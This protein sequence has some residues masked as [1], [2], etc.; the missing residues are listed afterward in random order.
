[1]QNNAVIKKVSLF[2]SAIAALAILAFTIPNLDVA[3]RAVKAIKSGTFSVQ[4]LRYDIAS[5]NIG[6]RSEVIPV[7][8][9][10]SPKD[11]MRQVFVPA[12]EFLMGRDGQPFQGAPPHSVYLDSYWMDQVEV[13]NA[14]YEGCVKEEACEPPTLRLNPYYGKWVYRNYPV[15]YVSWFQAQAYCEWAGRRLP[16]EAEFEKA[17]RGTDERKHP[18]GNSQP[19]PRHA[20]Y[21][22]ALIGEP[23]PVYRYPLGASPY[24]AL[25]M[26]GNVREWTADWYDIDYYFTS[27]TID[28]RGPET[29]IERAMRSGAYDADANEILTTSRYKHEPNSAGASRGFRCAEAEK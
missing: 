1:M 22:E 28:P 5:F 12:G 8:V 10:V 14:M 20:N 26:V 3:A 25:N 16:T 18:W 13:S 23:V 9:R 2:I 29:G 19:T 11:G 21:A 6:R 7:D 17:A 27:P 4:R 24:G 15:V